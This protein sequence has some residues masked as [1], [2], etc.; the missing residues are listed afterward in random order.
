LTE[1]ELLAG[2]FVLVRIHD[3]RS[4]PWRVERS[5]D[6]LTWESI[7]TATFSNGV[8]ALLETA[9]QG[10]GRKFYRAVSP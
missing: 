6:L 2:D 4:G 5:E 1:L 9:S 3:I 8:S 10:V 7:G